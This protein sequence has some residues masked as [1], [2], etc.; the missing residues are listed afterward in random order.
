MSIATVGR[1][2]AQLR[3]P[4][5]QA[6]AETFSALQAEADPEAL[7]VEDRHFAEDGSL[8]RYAVVGLGLYLL[9]MAGGL[10]TLLHHAPF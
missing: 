10:V 3:A 8:A 4:A 7:P 1:L 5:R 2:Q 6:P 9:A